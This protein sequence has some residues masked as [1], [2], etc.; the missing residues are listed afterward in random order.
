MYLFLDEFIPSTILV[1]ILELELFYY[2]RKTATFH[3]NTMI[4]NFKVYA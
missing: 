3:F 4:F 1:K 2:C